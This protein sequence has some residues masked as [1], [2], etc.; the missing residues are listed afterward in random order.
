M[1]TGCTVQRESISSWRYIIHAVSKPYFGRV[2]KQWELFTFM[3]VSST[4]PGVSLSSD[5]AVVVQTLQ[6][7]SNL[8]ATSYQHQAFSSFRKNPDAKKQ[9]VNG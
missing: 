6:S 2:K 3:K 5:F 1:D 7:Q 8:V 4:L 9:V